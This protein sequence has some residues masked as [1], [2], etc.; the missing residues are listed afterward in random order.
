MQDNKMLFNKQGH[1]LRK[2]LM[3][4]WQH[5]SLS[6]SLIRQMINNVKKAFSYLDNSLYR[7]TVADWNTSVV[8]AHGPN[9]NSQLQQNTKNKAD[10]N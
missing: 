1:I 7:R 5:A 9:F 10:E 2:W 6:M 4:L 3:F 8:C